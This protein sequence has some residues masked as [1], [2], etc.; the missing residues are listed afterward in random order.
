MTSPR[1]QWLGSWTEFERH[2]VGL[3]RDVDIP[4][5]EI[6]LC[7]GFYSSGNRLCQGFYVSQQPQGV[8]KEL[9]HKL[10]LLDPIYLIGAEHYLN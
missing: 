4:E 1:F 10:L 5:N 6:W 2:Q 7:S 9:S 8:L 3:G